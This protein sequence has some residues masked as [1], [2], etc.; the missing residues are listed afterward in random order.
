MKFAYFIVFVF[1]QNY[2]FSKTVEYCDKQFENAIS[3]S[4]PLGRGPINTK[5]V[6]EIMKEET[7]NPHCVDRQWHREPVYFFLVNSY[8]FE[9]ATTII[10]AILKKGWK[11]N[12]GYNFIN[13]IFDGYNQEDIVRFLKYFEKN[14][15]NLHKAIGI[16]EQTYG[17]AG[18]VRTAAVYGK[19]FVIE[20]LVRERGL[21]FNDAKN[22]NAIHSAVIYHQFNAFKKLLEL[23][24]KIFDVDSFG[25]TPLD[26]A[27]ENHDEVTIQYII[28]RKI[29]P[30]K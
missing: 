16:Y 29:T 23:G 21:S 5:L 28:E 27:I 4:A 24:A 10:D 11:T 3:A 13:G 1:F 19:E 30:K 14:G 18:L 7:F 12:S 17:L 15:L 9:S 2:A 25:K 22:Q 20:F 8:S 6:Y 26:Y